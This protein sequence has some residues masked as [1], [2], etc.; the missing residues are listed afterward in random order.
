MPTSHLYVGLIS[1]TSVDGVDCVVVD[2]SNEQPQLLAANTFPLP[3]NLREDVLRLCRGEN[4]SLSELGETNIA[5]GKEFAIA[6]NSLLATSNLSPQDIAAIGSH[7]QTVWHEPDSD[8]PFTLQLGDPNTIAQQTGVTTVADLRGRDMAAGGQGAPLAPLLHRAVFRSDSSNRAVVNIGSI[9]NITIL[10][11]NSV[12]LAYD[13]GPGNVLMDY[14]INKHRGEKFDAD[15]NWAAQGRVIENLLA[16]LMK[17]EYLARPAPKSTGRELFNASWLEQK[18]H[19]VADDVAPE[20][21]QA[22][23]LEFTVVSIVQQVNSYDVEELFVC[24]GGA[25][26]KTLMSALQEKLAPISVAST[27]ALGIDPDWVE[28]IAFAWMAK[29]S[30]EGNLV[31]SRPFTGASAPILLGGIFRA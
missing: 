28:A 10:P 24:G 5:L 11:T 9:S 16:A 14:W 30:I 27:S 26:N 19:E 2:L 13:T 25:H 22:T 3:D 20:D 15:G 6:A 12:C 29:Q 18:L 4:I 21:V 7:G 23:L 17:E 8:F 31:D 1:G